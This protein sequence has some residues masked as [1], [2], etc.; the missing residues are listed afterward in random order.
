MANG[1]LNVRIDE[2]LKKDA[3]E[4]FE[5]L[6]LNTSSAISMFFNQVVMTGGIPFPI[7]IPN[8][9]TIETIEK[10]ERGEGLTEYDSVEEMFK[11]S[12]NW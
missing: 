6:G 10:T 8:R 7:Y 12:K 3:K 11:D 5:R 9:K 2:K 1:T 4:I